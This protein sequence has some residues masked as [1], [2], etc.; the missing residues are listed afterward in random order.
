M[1]LTVR[2]LGRVTGEAFKSDVSMPANVIKS[3][4]EEDLQYY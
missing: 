1:I 3:E 2:H 4:D